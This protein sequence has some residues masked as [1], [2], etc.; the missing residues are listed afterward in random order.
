MTFSV[1]HV[2]FTNPKTA[3]KLLAMYDHTITKGAV[4]KQNK[5]ISMRVKMP[6]GYI[7][8]VPSTAVAGLEGEFILSI[9]FSKP[10]SRIHFHRL[11]RP[12]ENNY[13]AIKEESNNANAVPE[14]KVVECEK[15]LKFMIFEED[16]ADLIKTELKKAPG[17]IQLQGKKNNF[18]LNSAKK[19]VLGVKKRG[20]G[21]SPKK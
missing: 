13:Q 16:D 15:R 19:P 20:V 8:I 21:V 3:P 14:W 11:D 7:Y 12:S 17:K 9:Y 6:Q 5:E 4:V 1:I 10:K 18:K 2:P